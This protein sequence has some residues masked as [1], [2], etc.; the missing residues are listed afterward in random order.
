M[1][2]ADIISQKTRAVYIAAPV[3]MILLILQYICTAGLAS[4]HTLLLLALPVFSL[5][6]CY[7]S[8][9]FFRSN[10]DGLRDIGRRYKP[11]LA[12]RSTTHL[13]TPPHHLKRFVHHYAS[14]S[15]ARMTPGRP[16]AQGPGVNSEAQ[17]PQLALDLDVTGESFPGIRSQSSVARHP[18]SS[19]SY[20]PPLFR[21]G[22]VHQNKN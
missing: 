12:P 17:A 6:D 21:P 20:L 8:A 10:L 14:G 4:A 1:F 18:K 15:A 3:S 7:V 19:R 5:Y 16:P 2:T 11:V 13:S 22:S 9:L